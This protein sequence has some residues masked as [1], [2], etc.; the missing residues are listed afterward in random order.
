MQVKVN[1]KAKTVII[2]IHIR[3]CPQ[4]H[5]T[6]KTHKHAKELQRSVYRRRAI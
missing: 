1:A 3:Q 4:M 6:E 5:R 2:F